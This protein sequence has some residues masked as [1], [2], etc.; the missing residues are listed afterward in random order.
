M[1]SHW[2]TLVCSSFPAPP[3]SNMSTSNHI[4]PGFRGDGI[5]NCPERLKVHQF[6]KDNTQNIAEWTVEKFMQQYPHRVDEFLGGLRAISDYKAVSQIIRSFC[7]TQLRYLD[8]EFDKPRIRL[9]RAKIQATSNN[10]VIKENTYVSFQHRA[11]AQ[12]END[13]RSMAPSPPCG[14]GTDT[15]EMTSL[16][17]EVAVGDQYLQTEWHSENASLGT[18][19]TCR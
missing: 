8:S 1:K 11:I 4:G 19:A 14:S 10:G 13:M 15:R 18:Y 17:R 16:E 12:Q 6:F 9:M 2:V 7:V 3:S 5:F